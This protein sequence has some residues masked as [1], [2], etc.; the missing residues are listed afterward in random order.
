MTP[1]LIL[2]PG[3]ILPPQLHS[4]EPEGNTNTATTRTISLTDGRAC[5]I[6]YEDWLWLRTWYWYLDDK[7][8]SC[9]YVI[10]NIRHKGRLRKIRLHVEVMW[11]ISPPPTRKHVIVDHINNDTL[12]NR[13]CNLRWATHQE[14]RWNRKVQ[15]DRCQSTGRW[16][17]LKLSETASS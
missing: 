9:P 10:R 11:A 2:P 4:G 14:N 12:D 6:D 15:M 17:G 7:N 5:L 13:R 8:A 3:L 16:S 1:P